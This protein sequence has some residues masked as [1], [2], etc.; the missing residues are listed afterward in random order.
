MKKQVLAAIMVAMAGSSY[1]A[2]LSELQSMKASDIKE[3]KFFM[4]SAP[5]PDYAPSRVRYSKECRDLPFFPSDTPQS[6]GRENLSSVEYLEQCYFRPY[7]EGQP[8][9]ASLHTIEPGYSY[10]GFSWNGQAGEW[11][12][13]EVTGQTFRASAQVNLAPHKLYPWEHETFHVCMEGPKVT[14]EARNSPYVYRVDQRGNMDLTLDV[15]PLHRI[16]LNPDPEGL[17]LTAFS[18]R[19][20]KYTLKVDDKWAAEYAGESVRIR[21]ALMRDGFFGDHN[22]GGK[23]FTF[24]VSPSYELVFEEGELLTKGFAGF[25][26]DSRKPKKYYVNWGFFRAGSIS[27]GS[28]VAKGST[29]KITH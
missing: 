14:V 28:Y 19:D 24:A 8:N 25:G 23:D 11:V 2:D 18:Y 6:F 7:Q 4:D 12:C 27:S 17:S 29:G 20:G 13:R 15:T 22:L 16:R 5:Y 10:P 9:G 26:D 3:N 21:V 1:A